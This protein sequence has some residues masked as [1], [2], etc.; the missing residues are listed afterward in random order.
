MGKGAGN[1]R[2]K[3]ALAATNATNSVREAAART[4]GEVDDDSTVAT[5]R[6]TLEQSDIWEERRDAVEALGQVGGDKAVEALR[7]A[8]END[9][10]WRVRATA[11]YVL[12]KVGGDKAAEAVRRALEQDGDL[13]VQ[14]TAA[15]TLGQV[16]GGNAMEALGRALA[17]NDKW[18]I[19][20]AVVDALSRLDEDGAVR[21]LMDVA[22]IRG[23]DATD[24]NRL[25]VAMLSANEGLKKPLVKALMAKY[26]VSEPT[27]YRWLRK[28]SIPAMHAQTARPMGAGGEAAFPDAG[29]A[30]LEAVKRA[31]ARL[32]RGGSGARRTSASWRAPSARTKRGRSRSG[33]WRLCA[34][35]TRA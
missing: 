23:M 4:L 16:G 2:R 21:T 9:D 25:V 12:A 1:A 30:S 10:D 5:L 11:I 15:E 28:H 19:R 17:Q 34:T 13:S 14:M 3:A 31:A 7:Y 24:L 32:A 20:M 29:T 33:S 18:A 26:A 27:A 8:L 22:A 6:R 35:Q